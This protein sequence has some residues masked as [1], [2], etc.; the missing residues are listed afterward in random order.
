MKKVKKLMGRVATLNL[1]LARVSDKCEK[2]FHSLKASLNGQWTSKSKES[3]QKLKGAL[4]RL[5]VLVK[6]RTGDVLY[7]YYTVL[8]Y[9]VNSVLL[10]KE[11]GMQ[12]P[13]FFTSRVLRE[14]EARY[15][16]I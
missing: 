14:A 8:S 5:P 16:K 12:R 11:E 9:A 2:L 4:F 1:F 7:L 10:K 15:P 13:I 6:V 3:V